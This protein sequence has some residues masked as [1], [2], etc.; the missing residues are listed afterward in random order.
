MSCRQCQKRLRMPH[1]PHSTLFQMT[2]ICQDPHPDTTSSQNALD[3]L[4][5]SLFK[6]AA[7]IKPSSAMY[8]QSC[9]EIINFSSKNGTSITDKQNKKLINKLD[10]LL[11]TL[12]LMRHSNTMTCYKG[13]GIRSISIPKVA[14]N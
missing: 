1:S 10:G 8:Q 14:A 5:L 12:Q 9:W 11:F 6:R 4:Q 13:H 2:H 7:N 3:I